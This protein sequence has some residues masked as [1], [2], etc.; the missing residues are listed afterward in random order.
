MRRFW[1]DANQVSGGDLL[2]NTALNRA[3]AL[4]VRRNRFSVN[5]RAAHQEPRGTGLHE[6]N[7]HLRFMPFGLAIGFT[8]NQ[9]GGLVGEIR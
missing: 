6:D 5:E 7:V 4:F 1:R 3:I 9:Q 8:V 2:A